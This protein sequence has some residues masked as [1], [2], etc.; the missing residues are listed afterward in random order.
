[1]PE[2]MDGIEI[3]LGDYPLKDEPFTAMVATDRQA[4]KDLLAECTELQRKRGKNQDYVFE[5]TMPCGYSK[6]FK[7]YADIPLGDL[8]CDCGR[9]N[10]YLIKYK[11]E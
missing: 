9:T 8:L 11:K 10:R 6:K 1:M 7:E 2:V 3:S 4:I 5:I